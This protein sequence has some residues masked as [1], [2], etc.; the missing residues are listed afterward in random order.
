LST[1]LEQKEVQTLCKSVKVISKSISCSD[2]S[3][4]LCLFWFCPQSKSRSEFYEKASAAIIVL[5]KQK[6]WS[7]LAKDEWIERIHFLLNYH[8]LFVFTKDAYVALTL[9]SKTTDTF[10]HQS[11][12]NQDFTQVHHFSDHSDHSFIIFIFIFFF[13]LLLRLLLLLYWTWIMFRWPVS[14]R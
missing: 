3:F 10:W 5:Q 4:T 2:S 8:Y 13:L 14:F 9:W 11:L 12:Y 1:L 6:G 7:R